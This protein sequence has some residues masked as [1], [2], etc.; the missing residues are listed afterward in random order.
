[1]LEFLRPQHGRK[2]VEKEEQS[3]EA[4]DGGFHGG[5]GSEFVAE[6]NVESAGEEK[7]GHSEEVDEVSHGGV[8]V[9]SPSLAETPVPDE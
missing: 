6:A 8:L 3:D 4:G 1:V 7:G 9:A 5:S 2:E